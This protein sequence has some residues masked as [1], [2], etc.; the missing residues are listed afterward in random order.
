[1]VQRVPIIPGG[2]MI[3]S[4]VLNEKNISQVDVQHG[5]LFGKIMKN[6]RAL[7]MFQSSVIF[8]TVSSCSRV[9]STIPGHLP[10]SL[11]STAALYPCLQLK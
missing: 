10:S 6:V 1:M 7:Y 11:R 2:F 5:D 8:C 4:T 9:A 3:V